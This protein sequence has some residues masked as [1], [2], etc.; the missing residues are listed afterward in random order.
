MNHKNVYISAINLCRFYF[1]YGGESHFLASAVSRTVQNGHQIR[2]LSMLVLFY[3]LIFLHSLLVS[4]LLIC[5]TV[6]LVTQFLCLWFRFPCFHIRSFSSFFSCFPVCRS[7]KLP[8]NS[9]SM[10]CY[11]F[12]SSSVGRRDSFTTTVSLYTVYGC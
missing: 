5:A 12:H 2:L 1:G 3:F 11:F 8:E 10:V 7:E 6:S 4:F 9:G